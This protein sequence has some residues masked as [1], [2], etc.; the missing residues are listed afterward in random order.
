M[1]FWASSTGYT[2]IPI[3]KHVTRDELTTKFEELKFQGYKKIHFLH[4]CNPQYLL[5]ELQ[6]PTKFT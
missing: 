2:I 4:N 3:E 5:L 1:P 6:H